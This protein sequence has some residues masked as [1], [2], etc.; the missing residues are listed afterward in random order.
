MFKPWSVLRSPV[1]LICGLEDVSVVTATRSVH[2][3]MQ[4]TLIVLYLRTNQKYS[5]AKIS[6]IGT[7]HKYMTVSQTSGSQKC[8]SVAE[9]LSGSSW[10]SVRRNSHQ[11]ICS[12]P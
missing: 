5:G 6:R 4:L 8:H 12:K 1:T 3:G 7:Y 11:N 9:L 2:V 10:W